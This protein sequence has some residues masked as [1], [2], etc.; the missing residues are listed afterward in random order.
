MLRRTHQESD[1]SDKSD[2]LKYK[3]PK[4]I[5]HVLFGVILLFCLLSLEHSILHTLNNHQFFSVIILYTTALLWSMIMCFFKK[6]TLY[7]FAAFNFLCVFFLLVAVYNLSSHSLWCCVQEKDQHFLCNMTSTLL[8]RMNDE[9]INSWLCFGSLLS[10]VRNGFPIPWEH[11]FDI[12][13]DS[14]HNGKLLPIL[15]EEGYE[16]EWMHKNHIMIARVYLPMKLVPHARNAELWIDIY[17]Y[18][19]GNTGFYVN[20][21]YDWRFEREELEP[22]QKMIFCENNSHWSPKDPVPFLQRFYGKNYQQP[23]FPS[24]IKFFSCMLWTDCPVGREVFKG[25]WKK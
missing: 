3:R 8:S 23:V 19:R 7:I 5:T 15:Q 14:E 1:E 13:M 4:L 18:N 25:L 20:G 21:H 9:G 2:K 22:Q 12:C 17:R 10:A 24:G 11:D 16:F 6:I